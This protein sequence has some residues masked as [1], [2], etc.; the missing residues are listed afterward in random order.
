MS[1]WKSSSSSGSPSCLEGTLLLEHGEKA[2]R[3]RHRELHAAVRIRVSDPALTRD[4]L[5]WLDHKGCLAIQMG[6]NMV[7]VSLSE[8]LPYDAARLELDLHLTDWL[9]KHADARASVID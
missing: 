1:A 4:L 6:A 7:A 8:G 2:R 3:R 9:I 5:D